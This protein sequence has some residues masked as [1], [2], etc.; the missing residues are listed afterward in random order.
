MTNRVV[1]LT[2]LEDTDNFAKGIATT[3]SKGDVLALYGDLGVGKTYFTSRLCAYLGSS[4]TVNSP[5]YLIMN[6]Y[7]GK[8]LIFHLDLYR[9]GSQDEVLELGLHELFE[10]GITIIEWPQL[11]EFIMPKNT[12]KLFWTF[13]N[14]NRKVEIIK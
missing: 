4:D 10:S 9:L 5:S 3:L 14:N 11:A 1:I 2:S 6:E 7:N 8:Y 13:D 12:L